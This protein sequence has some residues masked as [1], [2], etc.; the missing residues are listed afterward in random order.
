MRCSLLG[1]L[2]CFS[3]FPLYAQER[4]IGTGALATLGGVVNLYYQGRLYESGGYTFE[5][6]HASNLEIGNSND[7]VDVTGVATSYKHYIESYLYGT[8]AKLGL[9]LLSMSD[10]DE[11]AS[12]LIPLLLVGYESEFGGRFLLGVEAGLGTT[13]GMGLFSVNLGMKL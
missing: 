11:S 12:G 9:A 6:A 10:S 13:A 1:L 3:A 4:I 5:F 2:L 8:Y 7:P